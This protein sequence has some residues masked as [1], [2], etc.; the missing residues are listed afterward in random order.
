MLESEQI[1]QLLTLAKVTG[2]Q[3]AKRRLSTPSGHS[4]YKRGRPGQEGPTARERAGTLGVTLSRRRECA[5]R[6]AERRATWAGSES[7]G[8]EAPACGARLSDKTHGANRSRRGRKIRAV[9][10]WGS[11]STTGKSQDAQGSG[12]VRATD[13]LEGNAIF[14]PRSLLRSRLV[15]NSVFLLTTGLP[16]TLGSVSHGRRGDVGALREVT[17]GG[18]ARS[19]V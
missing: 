19:W 3:T 14:L 4:W 18:T 2:Q 6:S 9:L 10:T 12:W 1:L 13:A 11:G 17:G 8:P 7:T 5:A 16:G 15:K